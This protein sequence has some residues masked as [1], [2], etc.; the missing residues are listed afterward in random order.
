VN[1]KPLPRID[2]RSL[3]AGAA[4][5]LALPR[6]WADDRLAV[7]PKPV[8][9]VITVYRPGSHSDVILGKILEGWSHDGGAG[10][11]LKLASMYV[12]QFPEDDMA[13]AMAERYGVPIF[14]SIEEAITLG[15]G[16]IPVEGVISIGEHGDYPWNE[17]EQHL[18]PRR[19]FF[20][21]ITD[22]FEKFGGVVPVFNDKHLGP[23]WE[24]AKWM[25]DRAKELNVPFMAGSSL[26]VGFRMPD[27]TVPMNCEIESAVGVG[28]SGLDIYGFHTLDCYQGLVERRSGAEQGV[29]WVQGLRGTAMWQ[30]VDD[31]TISRET[32]DA[33]LAAVPKVD[34]RDVRDDEEAAL[35][36][37]E[38][39]DGFLGSAY[40]LNTI[41]RIGAAVKVAGDPDTIALH[42]EERTEPRYPHFAYLLKGIERMVHTGSPSYPVERTYL[43]SGILDRALTSLHRGGEKLMTPELEIGYQPIDYPHAPHIDLLAA[44]T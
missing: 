4:A 36:L 39:M 30:A 13:R 41:G 9:A 28:Y 23:A 14:D 2:R 42:Y 37:F 11:A 22:T 17:L 21:E 38:Y 8:A 24:D 26:P 44:P 18:Y 7:E 3:L 6:A 20:T 35:F 15:S 27:V 43:T 32:L 19:R 1:E 10:P 16:S 31:G 40:M 5:T 12:D 33:A 25:Y 29:R 34:N